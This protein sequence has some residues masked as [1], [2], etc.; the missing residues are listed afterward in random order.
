[1]KGNLR[2]SKVERKTEETQISL[3]FNLDGQGRFEGSTQVPFL[4]HM[5]ALFTKHG[6][7]DLEIEAS[8]DIEVDDHH[9]VEDVG[10]SLG[11]ALLKSLGSKEG[12]NR[13]GSILLPMDEALV[14]CAVDISGRPYLAFPPLIRPT[15]ESS[16]SGLSYS[17]KIGDFDLSLIKEFFKAFTNSAKLTLHIKIMASEDI[18]HIIEAMFKALG[19]ALSQAVTINPRVKGLPSTKGK[20]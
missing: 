3:E 19:K 1:M 16:L 18:H 11:E 12:I 2:L 9:T 10:L 14:A 17:P 6:L 13:Y 7:F 4:D 8:G 5:L 15:K 20:L